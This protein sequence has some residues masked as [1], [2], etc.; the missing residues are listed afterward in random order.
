M[1]GLLGP[2]KKFE[3]SLSVD[4]QK[5]LPLLRKQISPFVIRRV[6]REVAKELPPKIETEIACQLSN[7]QKKVSTKNLLKKL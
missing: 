4:P 3:N 6:K 5:A 7:E 2:R 1:P